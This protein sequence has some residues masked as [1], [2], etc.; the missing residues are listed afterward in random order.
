MIFRYLGK[1]LFSSCRFSNC[2]RTRY[3]IKSTPVNL[4][5]VSQSFLLHV[6]YNRVIFSILQQ[7][8]KERLYLLDKG[9]KLITN[10]HK[11]FSDYVCWLLLIMFA[12]F[13]RNFGHF[14]SYAQVSLFLYLIFQ[15]ASSAIYVEH[16]G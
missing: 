16:H 11:T 1:T 6:F 9:G 14:K 10:V 15:C 12:P 3:A 2:V 5:N 7:S 8:P 4:I 13:F